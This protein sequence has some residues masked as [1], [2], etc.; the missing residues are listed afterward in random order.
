MSTLEKY[1]SEQ[2]V[3]IVPSFE[4]LE[5]RANV[6]DN[7]YSV[8]FF[9]TVNGKRMQCY[10]MVDD[11][12]IKEKDLDALSETIASYIRSTPDYEF[13][14]INKIVVAIMK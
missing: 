3:K 2:V 7:S 4:K 5:F 1:I 6:G 9:A 12:L 14:K 10:N 8:E 13:G 11:G